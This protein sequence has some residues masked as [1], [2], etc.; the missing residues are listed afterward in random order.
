MPKNKKQTVILSEQAYSAADVQAVSDTP[1]IT[2]EQFAQAKP[3]NDVFPVLAEK[4]RR[5]R[6]PQKAP[7]KIAVQLRL[8]RDVVER[9]R[10]SGKGWQSRI[11]EILKQA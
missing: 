11:N 10:A 1:E 7:T 4:M 5:A 6:G 9:F 8:D 3:F 2:A